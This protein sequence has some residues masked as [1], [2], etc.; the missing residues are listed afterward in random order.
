LR[1]SGRLIVSVTI[2]PDFSTIN[3]SGSLMG[4]DD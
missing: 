3:G 2:I 4:S 1:L